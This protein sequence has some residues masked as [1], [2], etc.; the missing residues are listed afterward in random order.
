MNRTPILDYYRGTG[1]DGAGRYRDQV[2]QFSPS[3]LET[4]HDYIQWLFPNQVPSPV[5]PSAPVVTARHRQ[6]FAQRP[7]LRQTDPRCVPVS[8]PAPAAGRNRRIAMGA[9]ADQ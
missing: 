8:L 6:A 1:V 7:Q 4:V 5:N 3:E 2:L 9:R